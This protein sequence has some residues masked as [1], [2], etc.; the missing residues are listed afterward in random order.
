LEKE[1]L[2]FQITIK[3]INEEKEIEKNKMEETFKKMEDL[4]PRLEKEKSTLQ[5]VIGINN[6]DIKIEKNSF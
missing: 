3:N 4:Q 2:D 1:T 6:S 5:I